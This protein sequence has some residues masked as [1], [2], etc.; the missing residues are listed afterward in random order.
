MTAD[1]GQESPLDLAARRLERALAMLEQRIQRR[2]SEA[3]AEAGGAYD[4]DR[5]KL[6]AEL[7]AARAR[8]RELEAA[9][10]AAYDALAHAVGE[11]RQVL[12]ENTD[13]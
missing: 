10:S 13:A 6:A 2:V 9:G 5:V 7:E 12:A 4:A 3:R 1:A 11:I 8:E